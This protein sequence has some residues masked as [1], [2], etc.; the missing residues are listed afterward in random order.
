MRSL[1]RGL[2]DLYAPFRCLA[3]RVRVADA[4]PLCDACVVGLV[5][6]EEPPHATLAA[7]AHGGPLRD[8]LHRAKYGADPVASARLGALLPPFLSSSLR[9]PVDL[10]AP[11]PLHP[12]RLRERGFNQAAQLAS[13]LRGL[14]PVRASLLERTRPTRPQVGLRK[15]ERERNVAGAFVA[16]SAAELRGARVLLVDDVVTTGATLRAL[17]SAL[18]DAGAARVWSVALA[19]APLDTTSRGDQ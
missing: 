5:P 16:R 3:C 19:S 2:F 4:R 15:R 8:A 17:E 1:L 6:P 11:V 14:A 9:E 7:F 12:S 13:A 18:L 10:V